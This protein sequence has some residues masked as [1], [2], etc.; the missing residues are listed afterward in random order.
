M[1][2]EFKLASCTT[3]HFKCIIKR[4]VVMF[5]SFFKKIKKQNAYPCKFKIKIKGAAVSLSQMCRS[6]MFVT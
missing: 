3:L 5:L 1:E 6:K 2:L 4:E